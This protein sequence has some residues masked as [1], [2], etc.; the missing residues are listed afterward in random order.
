MAG[1]VSEWTRKQAKNPSNPLGAGQYVIIGASF[2][3]TANGAFAR[4]W[5]NNRDT[6]RNDLGFRVGYDHQPE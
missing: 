4:E 6:K 3:K 2:E 1:G 5:T